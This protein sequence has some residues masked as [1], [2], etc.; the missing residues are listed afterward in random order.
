VI[1]PLT[2]RIEADATERLRRRTGDDVRAQ[3]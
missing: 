1:D 2:G 3:P